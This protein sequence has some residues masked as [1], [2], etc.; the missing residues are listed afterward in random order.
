MLCIHICIFVTFYI[1]KKIVIAKNQRLNKQK[2]SSA[3]YI[4]C[5]VKSSSNPNSMP[6]PL[7]AFILKKSMASRLMLKE[8]EKE[9]KVECGGPAPAY[10]WR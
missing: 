9:T 7:G 4:S 5:R 10:S 1:E 2:L 3:R 8:D 6:H